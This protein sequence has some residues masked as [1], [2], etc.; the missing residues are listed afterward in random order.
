EA[1][2]ALDAGSE[3][4]ISE[5]LRNLHPA[6]TLVVIAHRLST[7]Q[8]ADVVHVVEDGRVVASGDFATVQATVPMVA[9][10]VKLMS[11]DVI[12]SDVVDRDVIDPDVTET[13]NSSLVAME[14]E[15]EMDGSAD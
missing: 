10:Y 14:L 9:E 6:V 12:D 8:H 7:V 1:T 11:F 4:F 5:S 13:N 2:S 3:A 15:G